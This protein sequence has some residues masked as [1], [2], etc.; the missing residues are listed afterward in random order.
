MMT[1]NVPPG[2]LEANQTLTMKIYNHPDINT[3]P[4]YLIPPGHKQV[5]STP[6]RIT[7]LL[8]HGIPL[9]IPAMLTVKSEG[10]SALFLQGCN[11]DAN[12]NQNGCQVYAQAQKP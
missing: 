10:K 6:S 9:K 7:E 12:L 5:H 11:I 1:L 8:P 2:A 3:L 4:D